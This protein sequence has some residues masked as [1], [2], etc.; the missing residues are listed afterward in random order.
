[1]K[2]K[3]IMLCAVLLIASV[4]VFAAS[5]SAKLNFVKANSPMMSD[6]EKIVT[7]NE[8]HKSATGGF[9]L[10]TVIGCG[11]GSYSQGDILGGT[12][13][14]C[15]EIGASTLV[16][17]GA[18]LISN[19]ELNYETTRNEISRMYQNDPEGYDKA[20]Q[21]AAEQYDSETTTGYAIMI[22]GGVVWGGFKI[23]EMIRPFTFANKFNKQLKDA[24][25]ITQIAVV[26]TYTK[27]NQWGT[28]LAASMVF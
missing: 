19:A 18:M 6:F 16:G 25:G 8:M 27:D 10:N 12:V 22:T 7:Y 3:I 4:S 20:S 1:M 9:L 28:T 21:R 17:V 11:V 24:F 14:L 26:P 13:G 2:K 23:F 5:N 15:G